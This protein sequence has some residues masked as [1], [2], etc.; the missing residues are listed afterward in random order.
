MKF[1]LA[2]ILVSLSLLGST[3]FAQ[4]PVREASKVS[5]DVYRFVNNN[6]RSVFIITGHGVVVTDPINAEAATWLRAKIEKLT[7]QPITGI[8]ISN[9]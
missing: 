1:L 9:L 2:S 6:H 3:T 4:E 8:F 7:D 5:G